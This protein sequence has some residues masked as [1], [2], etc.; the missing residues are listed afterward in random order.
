MGF[1]GHVLTFPIEHDISALSTDRVE[2]VSAKLITKR[3]IAH[4]SLS[5]ELTMLHHVAGMEP[6]RERHEAL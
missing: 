2:S 5:S 3:V 6:E 4:A 1:L